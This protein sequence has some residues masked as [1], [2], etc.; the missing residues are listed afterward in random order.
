MNAFAEKHFDYVSGLC[1]LAQMWSS[2]HNNYCGETARLWHLMTKL[3]IIITTPSHP[4]I[5]PQMVTQ[6]VKE[7]MLRYQTVTARQSFED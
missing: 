3:L 5:D 2:Q 7:Q 6:G 1:R 4:V